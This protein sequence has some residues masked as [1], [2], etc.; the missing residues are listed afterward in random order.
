VRLK[1]SKTL[2]VVIWVVLVS[3]LSGYAWH[4]KRQANAKDAR[5]H[6]LTQREFLH[7]FQQQRHEEYGDRV[8]VPALTPA[9]ETELADLN[10]WEESRGEHTAP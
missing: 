8:T 3:S 5:W 1:A 6:Y 4:L 7:T 10:R 9:E 2:G